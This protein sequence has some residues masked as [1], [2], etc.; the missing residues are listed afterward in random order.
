MTRLRARKGNTTMAIAIYF[1]KNLLIPNITTND[2]Y[3][4]RQLSYFMFNVHVLADSSYYFF[5][6]DENIE[7]KESDD[8]ASHL[9]HFIFNEIKIQ[10]K[11]LII[12]CDSRG[13]QNKNY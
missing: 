11:S 3:Y 13:G 1:S 12:F 7:T 10:V 4:K 2:V 8:V 5:A 6:Y 9:F